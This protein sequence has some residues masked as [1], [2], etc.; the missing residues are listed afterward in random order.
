MIHS[1]KSNLYLSFGLSLILS[2][3]FHIDA[4]FFPNTVSKAPTNLLSELDTLI[5]KGAEDPKDED[6]ENQIKKLMSTISE[7]RNGDQRK[8]LSG[9]W[10]LVY[11]T[12]KEVNFFKTSWPFAKVSRITQDLDLYDSKVINNSIKFDGGGEFNVIGSVRTDESDTGYDRV[13][14]EFTSGEI[15][16]WDKSLQVPP[17]GKG[18]FDTM[19]C[20]N[21]IR[22]SQDLRDDWSIFRRLG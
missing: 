10:E 12:E 8:N 7:S 21:K 22:L 20:D 6:L 2:N 19:Y 17:I 4:F 11:T 1:N 5:L 18:W 14:F 16:A 3:L 13:S 9:K 15:V